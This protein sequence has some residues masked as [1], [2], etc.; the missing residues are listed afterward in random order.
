M[1]FNLKPHPLV[2]HWVPGVVACFVILASIS[3]WEF[4]KLLAFVSP[5]SSGL[6]FSIFIITVLAFVVGQLLDGLRNSFLESRWDKKQP[7]KWDFF[8]EA[9]KDRIEV[10][11]DN[12]FT[13]Y[14]FD[15]NMCSALVIGLLSAIVCFLVA[16]F[17]LD[18]R[19]PVS[20][21]QLPRTIIF[22]LLGF[23]TIWVLGC[24]A[25]NL[26]LEIKT[27]IDKWYERRKQK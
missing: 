14:A 9:E 8:F 12:Y 13:W 26:R 2:A 10:M 22:T 16:V 15:V 24:D 6:I 27:N 7:I 3:R 5:T 1:D 17:G 25:K 11:D 18:H 20:G 4:G 21:V 19:F 23:L